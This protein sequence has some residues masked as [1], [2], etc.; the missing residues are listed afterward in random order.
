[1]IAE[2]IEP[3]PSAASARIYEIAAEVGEPRIEDVA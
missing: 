2:S 1:M 3:D